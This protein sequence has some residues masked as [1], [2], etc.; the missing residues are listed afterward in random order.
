MES[1]ESV[2]GKMPLNPEQV[3]CDL[4]EIKKLVRLCDRVNGDTI[5][6]A[7]KAVELFRGTLFEENYYDWT[8]LLQ[9]EL[10]VQYIELLEKASTYCLKIGDTTGLRYFERKKEVYEIIG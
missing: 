4:Y 8:N 10:D 9:A 6:T 5:G 2:R 7:R 3:E 1:L